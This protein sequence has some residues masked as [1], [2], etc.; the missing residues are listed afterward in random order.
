MSQHLSVNTSAFI[1]AL[2]DQLGFTL[3]D[4]M[5]WW[6]ASTLTNSPEEFVEHLPV[7]VRVSK[8]GKTLEVGARKEDI[9][10]FLDLSRTIF[11]AAE[12]A[13]KVTS[14]WDGHPT[15]S[16]KEDGDYI[17][18]GRDI[19]PTKEGF[20]KCIVAMEDAFSLAL[21]SAIYAK[22]YNT[23]KGSGPNSLDHQLFSRIE[24]HPQ[25]SHIFDIPEQPEMEEEEALVF[26]AAKPAIEVDY[27]CDFPMKDQS[28]S[29][30]HV[31]GKITY[32]GTT[33][34]VSGGFWIIADNGNPNVDMH[35]HIGYEYVE[36][37]LP[38]PEGTEI[39]TVRDFE[40]LTTLNV[41]GDFSLLPE[42]TMQVQVK[43]EQDS[44]RIVSAD[45]RFEVQVE[46]IRCDTCGIPY[47]KFPSYT[48]S[49]G[50]LPHG[51]CAPVKGEGG[52][53]YFVGDSVPRK[54][55]CGTCYGDLDREYQKEHPLTNKDNAV[56]A[57]RE[58]LDKQGYSNVNIDPEY[59]ARSCD[60]WQADVAIAFEKDGVRVERC[61]GF[62]FVRD[63]GT[64]ELNMRPKEFLEFEYGVSPTPPRQ[65][66]ARKF[67][68]WSKSPEY[69]TVA[70]FVASLRLHRDKNIPIG[71]QQVRD[72]IDEPGLELSSEE[73]RE[74][75]EICVEIALN[76]IRRD[77]IPGDALLLMRSFL[78][79]AEDEPNPEV[80]NQLDLGKVHGKVAEIEEFLRQKEESIPEDYDHLTEKNEIACNIAALIRVKEALSS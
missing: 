1:N 5:Q 58:E 41:T 49:E 3:S 61:A 11:T 46:N 12:D 66:I 72:Q 57:I 65:I 78:T 69:P 25:I 30:Q 8:D 50:F 74:S 13:D 19:E 26:P 79:T 45:G 9:Q 59:M 51:S 34:S 80:L 68:E 73:A 54:C 36:L 60:G 47:W 67:H 29:L 33:A 44:F 28:H 4:S 37:S 14:F 23:Y 16:G 52:V 32:D 63:D 71:Y 77:R 31:P 21:H 17:F 62:P 20:E 48:E 7:I 18:I 56:R 76:E 55:Y 35:A 15:Y 10:G 39:A 38:I 27:M 70:Q 2:R 42:G 40:K 24:E 6:Q 43:V 22:S 53:Q 64:I 75:F